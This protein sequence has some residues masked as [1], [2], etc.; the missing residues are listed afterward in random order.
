MGI[1]TYH[2]D[3]E[4]VKD[5]HIPAG[6]IPWG[7]IKGLKVGAVTID[8]PSIAG[9]ATANVDVTVEGLTTDHQVIAVCQSDLEHGLIPIAAYVPTANTLRIRLTNF[10]T[11]AIDGIARPWLYIAWIP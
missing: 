9:G 2:L 7:D 3:R 8:P 1:R 6:E 4:A 11:L 5:E 10:T